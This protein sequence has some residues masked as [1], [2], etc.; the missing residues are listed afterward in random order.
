MSKKR[1]RPQKQKTNQTRVH[2]ERQEPNERPLAKNHMLATPLRTDS[3]NVEHVNETTPQLAEIGRTGLLQFSGFLHEEDLRQLQDASKRRKIYK[4]MRDN[5]PII[6]AI[7]FTI[8]MLMRQVTWNFEPVDDEP[9]SREDA[10]FADSLLDDMSSSWQD[11]L[12]EIMSFIPW[13]WSWHETVLKVRNG[14]KPGMPGES[15]KF[16]DGRIGWRKIPIRGQDTLNR[17]LFD[18]EGGLE[19]MQQIPAPD[20]I[21]RDI[22]I[23]RSLLF[24]TQVYKNNPEGKALALDTPILT[25]DGW[26]TM[27]TVQEGDRVFDE[28]GRTR[29]VTAKTEVWKN[30]ESY[31]ILFNTGETI[32]ADENHEWSVTS[33]NDRS[34]TNKPPHI[35]TTKSMYEKLQ[36]NKLNCFSAGS[37]SAIDQ[38]KQ[39]LS[40]DPYVLGYWLG[41]G[42]KNS[43]ELTVSDEDWPSLKKQ[44]ENAGYEINLSGRKIGNRCKVYAKKLVTDLRAI[45]VL[46]DKHIPE[47]YLRGN[48]EQRL[49]LLQGLMDSDGSSP[50]GRRPSYFCNTNMLLINGV[51]ELLASLGIVPLKTSSDKASEKKKSYINGVL[52]KRVQDCNRVH[53][54]ANIPVHR[55]QRKLDT[56]T[57]DQSYRV[58]NYFIQNIKPVERQ[59]TVCIEVDSPNHLFLCGRS[60]I[61]THNSLFRS[62]F[63]PWF[64]KK[65]IETFEAIGVE[66]DLAGFPV[67]FV[68][69]EWTSAGATPEEKAAYEEA[70][71]MIINIK[72]DEQEG[73]VLPSIFD[74]DKNRTLSIEL[75]T[76]GGKRNF[77]TDKIIQ[78]YNLQIAL[79]ALMDFLLLGHEKVGSFALADSK[80]NLSS[81]ALGTW[82]DMIAAVFNRHAVPRLWEINGLDMDKIPQLKHSDLEIPDLEII[83]T[84]V[85]NLQ[86]AGLKFDDLETQNFLRRMP[87]FPE[88]DEDF[89]ENND[90][91]VEAVKDMT[92]TITE[93]VKE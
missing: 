73:L 52:I 86:A 93:A 51:R 21:T 42:S 28:Q 87:G 88:V 1:K 33:A 17:W 9:S 84:F 4:E 44:V 13:G 46:T 12:S 43:G 64:F 85:K 32:I 15:S 22:P 57:F 75:L 37:P 48:Y 41:D 36:K 66:R 31:E 80:T 89:I 50:V 23:Q 47:S 7:L 76:S 10:D 16:S 63:R 60:L 38:P 79:T 91:V 29:Y 54:W 26:K 2:K 78:R 65:R 39:W 59:D 5:D 24:R 71:N 61:P 68:P 67:L 55:L 53:F 62:M 25:T 58:K 82:L 81:V 20:Y 56:Q 19:G 90:E 72:R 35:L 74:D 18:E 3:S 83:G 49:G 70:K 34:H 30:R 14:H 6:G 69:S 8:D 27:E 11:T 45:G 40:V 77:D 92:K